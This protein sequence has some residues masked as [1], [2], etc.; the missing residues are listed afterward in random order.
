MAMAMASKGKKKSSRD[1]DRDHDYDDDD[2]MDGFIDDAITLGDVLEILD[3]F[4]EMSGRQIIFTSNHI[5][6]LDPALVRK[7]RVDIMVEFRNMRREDVNSMYDLWFGISIPTSVYAKMKD[8][9]FSQADLG[10]LFKTRDMEAID[11]A[12]AMGCVV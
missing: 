8:E 3:G 6:A 10:N 12:L 1:R 7:G 2:S 11:K 5:E 4:V 9:A